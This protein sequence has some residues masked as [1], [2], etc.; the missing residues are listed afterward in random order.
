MSDV[1]DLRQTT[2]EAAVTAFVCL[3]YWTPNPEVPS[4]KIYDET[5]KAD[6][7]VAF[8]ALIGQDFDMQ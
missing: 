8:P 2:L 1:F 3:E 5:A 6:G 7:E 4:G